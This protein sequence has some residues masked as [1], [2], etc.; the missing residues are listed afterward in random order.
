MPRRSF[1]EGMST[2]GRS[3][4]TALRIR[5]SMS[6]IGSVIMAGQ[7]PPTAAGNAPGPARRS[8]AGRRRRG[9]AP[10]AINQSISPTRLLDARDQTPQGQAPEADPADAEL[11]VDG[12]RAT[13]KFAAVPMPDRELAGR[14][15][16]DHLGFGRHLGGSPT[17]G[18][19]LS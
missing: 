14:L 8:R 9:G 6:A 12:A 1:E 16:L 10:L 18:T 7:F 11:A 2:T 19:R 13:A 15:R 3:I 4:R 5:V 17:P